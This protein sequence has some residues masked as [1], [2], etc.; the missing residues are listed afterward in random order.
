MQCAEEQGGEPRAPWRRARLGLRRRRFFPRPRP[1]T[2]TTTKVRSPALCPGGAGRS[3]RRELRPRGQLTRFLVVFLHL[4]FSSFVRRHRGVVCSEGAGGHQSG[5][6]R[7]ERSSWRLGRHDRRRPVWLGHGH[8]Q[9]GPSLRA[10]RSLSLF[11]ARFCASMMVDPH[12]N[13]VKSWFFAVFFF[14]LFAGL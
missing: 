7:P 1:R 12:R 14:G 3:G 9:P 4:F 10:V 2:L 6:D 11:L 8:L 13:Q 5:A